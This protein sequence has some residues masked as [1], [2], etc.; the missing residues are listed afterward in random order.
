MADI[1]KS[2]N[3]ENGGSNAT[4]VKWKGLV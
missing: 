3:I 4:E 1:Q 2:K